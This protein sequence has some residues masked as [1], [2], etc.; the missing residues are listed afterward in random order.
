[1]KATIIIPTF[2]ALEYTRLC[3]YS[4]KLTTFFPHDLIFVDNGS[5]DGTIEFLSEF[6][7]IT[8]IRSKTNLGY[9]GACNLGIKKS[10]SDY[11]VISNNDIFF[12]PYWLTHLVEASE[13]FPN[14]GLV[15]P[16]T[17]KAAGFHV[18][19]HNAYNCKS[20]L[21]TESK[22]IY[23]KYKGFVQK[24]TWLVFFCTLIKRETIDAVGILDPNLGLGGCDDVDYSYRVN[25]SGRFCALARSV[26]VHH[27][28]SR[29]YIANKLDYNSLLLE[30]RER[31]AKKWK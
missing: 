24:V 27:F 10:D 13:S 19:P 29:T 22:R 31:F 18:I 8:L 30:S 11:I 14:I 7:N 1:M 2:N 12:T 23:E 3:L 25:Q 20:D 21:F 9:A 17:N 6:S 16:A 28:C 5:T 4:L 26:Y 15:G